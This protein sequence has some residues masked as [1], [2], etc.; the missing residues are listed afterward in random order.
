VALA[1]KTVT[2]GKR[3]PSI[4]HTQEAVTPVWQPEALEVVT[5]TLLPPALSMLSL[6]QLSTEAARVHVAGVV[7]SFLFRGCH[8]WILSPVNNTIAHN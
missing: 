5:R 3:F 8:T 2:L 7:S 6:S 1:D 4:T